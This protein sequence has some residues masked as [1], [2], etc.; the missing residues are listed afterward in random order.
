MKKLFYFCALALCVC[1]AAIVAHKLVNFRRCKL[2]LD[3]QKDFSQALFNRDFKSFNDMLAGAEKLFASFSER[4]KSAKISASYGPQRDMREVL[5]AYKNEVLSEG[6]SGGGFSG[7][8]AGF[9]EKLKADKDAFAY[10]FSEKFAAAENVAENAKIIIVNTDFYLE[11]FCAENSCGKALEVAALELTKSLNADL[12]KWGARFNARAGLPQ[13]AKLS[14][15]IFCEA[16]EPVGGSE[17]PAFAAA[18]EKAMSG[19][20]KKSKK[21]FVLHLKNSAGRDLD[22]LHEKAYERVICVYLK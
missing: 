2:E 5:E 14:E 15:M 8:Y 19:A 16:A 1:L 3:A 11:D 10:V 4:A 6:E 21:S 22:K 12:K 18:L 7:L 20:V 9:L 13:N 17:F